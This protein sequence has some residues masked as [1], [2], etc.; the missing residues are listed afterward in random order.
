M[1]FCRGGYEEDEVR[2]TFVLGR[3]HESVFDFDFY[4][5]PEHRMGLAFVGLWNAAN[6]YLHG[7]GVRYTF[8]RLTRFNLASRRAHRH[9]GWRVVGRAL[10]LCLGQVQCMLA[11]VFPYVHVSRK[12]SVRLTLFPGPLQA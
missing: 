5:F 10:F 11:T 12:R 9:L 6:E 7:A 3:A 2:C 8:S 1:W 4:I